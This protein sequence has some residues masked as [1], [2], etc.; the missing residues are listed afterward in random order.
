MEA[1]AKMMKTKDS[2]GV[3]RDV[4]YVERAGFD[5]HSNQINTFDN[6]LLPSVNAGIDEFK[7]AM[8]EEGL[9]DSVTIVMVSEFGRTL[10][11]NTAGGSDHGMLFRLVHVRFLI[12]SLA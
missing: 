11:E 7:R 3:E 2:R 10:Q 1:V 5:T 8:V 12:L 6:L 9:W 4:F